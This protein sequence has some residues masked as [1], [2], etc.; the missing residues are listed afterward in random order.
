MIGLTPW[1]SAAAVVLAMTSCGSDQVCPGHVDLSQGQGFV[2]QTSD[3]FP[4]IAAVIFRGD[5][6]AIV[7]ASPCSFFT[8]ETPDAGVGSGYAQV[9]V[10]RGSNTFIDSDPPSDAK[11]AACQMDVTSVDGQ[12]VTVT[13]NTILHHKV[14]QHCVGNS[15]CCPTSGLEWLGNREFYPAVATV[16][17]ARAGD[18]S[19]DAS[20]DGATGSSPMDLAAGVDSR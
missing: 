13:A 5:P 9:I 14:S 15:N 20:V 4:T 17:F 11:P 10:H 1:L 19:V 2:I 3:G 6:N 12:S 8:I 16:P 18:A 7:G